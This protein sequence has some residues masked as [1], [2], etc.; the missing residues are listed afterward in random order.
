M[1][2]NYTIKELEEK[3]ENIRKEINKTHDL[4]IALQKEKMDIYDQLEDLKNPIN[5]PEKKREN[6]NI[7]DGTGICYRHIKDL[8]TKEKFIEQLNCYCK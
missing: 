8:R 4:Y 6:C 7:C 3:L 2:K 1:V 5:I